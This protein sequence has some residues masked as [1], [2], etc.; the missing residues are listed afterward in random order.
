MR[1]PSL[2]TKDSAGRMLEKEAGSMHPLEGPGFSPA[3]VLT[4][5]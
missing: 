4:L 2:K 3:A 1:G 5:V